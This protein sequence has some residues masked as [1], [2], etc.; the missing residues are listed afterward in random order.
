MRE[1][2]WPQ[3]WYKYISGLVIR[4]LNQVCAE[5]SGQVIGDILTLTWSKVDK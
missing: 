4:E 1:L 5:K 2:N 3:Y